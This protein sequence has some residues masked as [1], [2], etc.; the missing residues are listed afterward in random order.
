LNFL[1][2]DKYQLNINL[3]NPMD[4]IIQK[5]DVGKL[6]DELKLNPNYCTYLLDTALESGKPN[7][8]KKLIA[9][10]YCKPSLYAVQM[11]FVNG[12]TNLAMWSLRHSTPR[13]DTGIDTVHTHYDRN[14]GKHIWDK[15]IPEEF[16]Y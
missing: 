5:D 11:A 16:R 3:S 13:N 7:I 1:I 2:V 10:E 14:L 8:T 9:G 12:H 6:S 15:C 4:T